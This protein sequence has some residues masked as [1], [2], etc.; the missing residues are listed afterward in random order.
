[1]SAGRQKSCAL[2]GWNETNG[3]KGLWLKSAGSKTLLEAHVPFEIPRGDEL[4]S[5]LESVLSVVYLI[6][7]EGYTATAGEEWIW[8]E[9]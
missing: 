5:R 8:E 1:M 7:N 6:F 9:L 2:P 4:R 3:V